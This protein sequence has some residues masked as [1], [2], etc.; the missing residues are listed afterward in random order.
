MTMK[1]FLSLVL[2]LVMILSLIPAASAAE[3][4]TELIN[5]NSLL[6]THGNTRTV[7]YGNFYDRLGVNG[8]IKW[9]AI[10]TSQIVAE[11]STQ[12]NQVGAELTFKNKLDVPATLRFKYTFEHDELELEDK[13]YPAEL[14][15]V[16][17]SPVEMELAAGATLTIMII[18]PNYGYGSAVLTITDLSLS[19]G[20]DVTATFS[21]A[22][23]GSYTV[24]GTEVIEET[25]YPPAAVGTTYAV[26]AAAAS[27]YRFFG[28]SNDTEYISY[29]ANTTLTVNEDCTIY[30]VFIRD[31]VAVFGVG[32]M[33]FDNLTDADTYAKNGGNKTIV[34]M[35]DGILTGEHTVSA[36]NTLLIP[37]DD[38]NT[39][40]TVATSTAIQK[41]ESLWEN[42]PWETPN[43]YRTLT[44][45]EGAKITVQGALNVG[46]RHSAGP[47]LTAG[48]P[49]GDLGMI[50]MAEGTNITVANGGTLYCWGYI[51]GD[52]TVDVNNGGTV[53]ENFQFSDFRG[54]NITLGLATSFLVFPMS[55]YYV[56]NVEVAMTFV[57][58][59][60]EYVWGSIYLE[61]QVYGTSVKFIGEEAV[62]EDGT[63][64]PCMFIPKEGSSVT[65][66]YDPATDRLVIDIDGDGSINPMGLALGGYAIDTK[67]FPLPIN[68]NMTVNINSGT[69]K[70]N[71]SL[72]LLPGSELTIA[73]NATL[74]VESAEPYKK[75]GEYLHYTGANNLIV[76]DREQWFNAYLPV[77]VN[78]NVVGATPT[79]TQFVYSKNGFKR[80][81]PIAWS[82]TCNYT[83]TENDLVDA[84]VDINGT[85]VTN[86]FIYTTVAVDIEK[87]F[88]GQSPVITGDGAAVI[89]SKGTGTLAMNNGGGRDMITLQ[90]YQNSA[91]V[92]YAYIPMASARLQ[93]ADGSYTDTLGA[94]IG[95][96]YH[97]CKS[98]G[99]WNTTA[100][101]LVDI[102]WIVEGQADFTQEVC[103][104]TKPVY[105]LGNDPELDGYKFIGWST[106]D[107][108]VPEYT[109]ATLPNVEGE[110]TY[111]ACFQKAVSD[112]KGD[113]DLDWDVD[114]DDLTALAEHVAG[115]ETLKDDNALL[116]ADTLENGE[117]DIDD[118]TLHACYVAGII[119]DWDENT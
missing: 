31:N 97:F 34:L 58:G 42:V 13:D 119:S 40:H 77:I 9:Q 94:K 73:E 37:Y 109:S 65:K 72:A 98:C 15:G 19:S 79:E 61:E 50:Q 83:R 29:E 95:T 60:S 39:V 69:T 90:P 4:E 104:G 41:S 68:S 20:N 92:Q 24:N 88:I 57:A 78:G 11:A 55:Q 33:R 76:Y 59:A 63:R 80:L 51:Y 30:P 111:Y 64:I 25:A 47:F 3:D 49:S 17:G 1:R 93:N 52:G 107:D 74:V 67:D 87:S 99:T 28:W 75:D 106:A 108:D 117:V 113:L 100:H 23:N 46:G 10:G 48:S 114:I 115:I 89:S 8:E 116:N 43:A 5:T 105:N 81:Q 22:K 71:Q 56:Q 7:M 102:C 54:G 112:L 86:G 110:V 82:P 62:D 44:M 84:V 32:G 96:S 12:G 118:L 53:H 66:R 6:V 91:N 85:L 27:G 36:G 101:E 45:E 35:N 18:S 103:K 26:S 70:L 16:N 38:D 2:A 14:R 21:P